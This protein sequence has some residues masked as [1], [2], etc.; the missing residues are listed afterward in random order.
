MRQAIS[1][2]PF[3]SSSLYLSGVCTYHKFHICNVVHF[4]RHTVLV[5]R[6]GLCYSIPDFYPPQIRNPGGFLRRVEDV[7]PR[8][9][10]KHDGGY[11]LIKKRAGTECCL[12]YYEL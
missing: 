6:I 3:Q 4:S 9:I 12:V 1:T 2:A 11:E 7:L 8:M 5:V 10:V